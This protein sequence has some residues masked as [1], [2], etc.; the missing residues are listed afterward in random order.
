MDTALVIENLAQAVL[1]GT[2]DKKE[3][4]QAFLEKRTAAFSGK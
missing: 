1:Y 4:T 2:N 3:G